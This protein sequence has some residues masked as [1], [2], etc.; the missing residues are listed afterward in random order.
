MVGRRT[1]VQR[2]VPLRLSGGRR[3]W[4]MAH[5]QAV[6]V[7]TMRTTAKTVSALVGSVTLALLLAS[8]N[9]G[10]QEPDP[11]NTGPLA[12]N[13]TRAAT[14][15]TA[16]GATVDAINALT[17]SDAVTT[18]NIE[19]ADGGWYLGTTPTS[20]GD[21]ALWATTVDPTTD[22]FDGT[23]FPLNR[24]ATDEVGAPTAT[25]SPAPKTFAADSAAASRV[26]NCVTDGAGK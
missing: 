4:D 7:P 11:A 15:D 26:E 3:T 2:L 23:V 20:G 12:E 21:V 6:S 1:G 22:D 14:C 24:T 13:T 25:A 8:C 16:S 9:G 19:A 5:R 10:A 18:V 17:G